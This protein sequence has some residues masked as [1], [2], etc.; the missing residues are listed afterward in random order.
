MI[1]W[2]HPGSTGVQDRPPPTYT[3]QTLNL[4]HVCPKLITEWE[5]SCNFICASTAFIVGLYYIDE[6]FALRLC[7]SALLC[8]ILKV[9]KSVGSSAIPTLSRFFLT[10]RPTR[11]GQ[12][13]VSWHSKTDIDQSVRFPVRFPVNSRF[14]P[15]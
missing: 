14:C 10:L 3:C 5:I 15:N 2:E 12:L 1:I 8:H 13:S 9:V 7:Y 11:I 4:T 6:M